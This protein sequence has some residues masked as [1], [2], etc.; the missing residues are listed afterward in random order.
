MRCIGQVMEG[1]GGAQGFH[2]HLGMTYSQHVDVF[3]SLVIPRFLK[4]SLSRQSCL[5]KSPVTGD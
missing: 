1:R 2:D 5:L 4:V 3:T